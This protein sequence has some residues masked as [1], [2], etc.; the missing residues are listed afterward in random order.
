M[1]IAAGIGYG[2]VVL[3]PLPGDPFRWSWFQREILA[4][5]LE[6]H[7]SPNYSRIAREIGREDEEKVER[8]FKLE[9]RKRGIKGRARNRKRFTAAQVQKLRREA[10]QGDR[11]SAERIERIAR[12]MG[13]DKKRIGGW[14]RKERLRRGTAN[15]STAQRFW[16]WQ[17]DALR[18]EANDD[19]RPDAERIATLS[20]W[21]GEDKKRLVQWFCHERAARGTQDKGPKHFTSAQVTVLRREADQNDRPDAARIARIA[22]QLGEDKKRVREWFN[23]ERQRRGTA[24][25][26]AKKFTEEQLTKLRAAL[27]EDAYPD[28]A[29]V[30]AEVGDTEKRVRKWFMNQRIRLGIYDKARARSK[31]RG[32]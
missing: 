25:A 21:I 7:P 22:Q 27:A 28:Y 8:W 11:P 17:K 23:H 3:G 18:E 15:K 19:D 9:R 13:E 2:G 31:M 20:E 24:T 30:A 1:D 5:E 10:D 4:Y 14:F 6:Q 16:R 29:R 12:Q 26:P 32:E